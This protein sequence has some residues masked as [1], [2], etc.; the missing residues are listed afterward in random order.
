MSRDA[1]V[2]VNELGKI[3][4]GLGLAVGL[5]I[6]SDGSCDCSEAPITLGVAEAAG[7]AFWGVIIGVIVG[8]EKWTTVYS[9]SRL[10]LTGGAAH[11]QARIGLSV[12]Y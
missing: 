3:T 2:V 9:P 12:R 11:G 10:A 7:G 1:T 5:A 6:S 8:A 4:G